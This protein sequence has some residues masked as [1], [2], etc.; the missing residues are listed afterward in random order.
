MCRRWNGGETIEKNTF[1]GSG[2]RHC[3]NL[4]GADSGLCADQLWGNSH[5]V[6]DLRNAHR[7][8]FL[9]ACRYSG[10][11]YRRSYFQSVQPRGSDRCGPWQPGYAD[12]RPFVL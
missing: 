6:P 7:T 8:P 5:R 11:I 1:S 4:C 12:R 10:P 2:S 9:H 3:R